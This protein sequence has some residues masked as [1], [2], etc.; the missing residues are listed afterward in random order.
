MILF[1]IA[2]KIILSF[3]MTRFLIRSA[4]RYRIKNLLNVWYEIYQEFIILDTLT[5]RHTDIPQ[6]TRKLRC[7]HSL[8]YWIKHS[9]SHSCTLLFDSKKHS[10]IL[11][12]DSRQ[13]YAKINTH[14][15]ALTY[16][17]LKYW[18]GKNEIEN[19]QC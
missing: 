14:A 16:L 1:S 13:T 2:A 10:I 12:K 11:R 15:H 8:N 4:K 9:L 18:V 7:S 17:K 19:F 5:Q 3:E 6:N